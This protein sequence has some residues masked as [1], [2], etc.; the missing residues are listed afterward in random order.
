MYEILMIL[1]VLTYDSKKHVPHKMYHLYE[2]NKIL[3]FYLL[4]CQLFIKLKTYENSDRF[5]IKNCNLVKIRILSWFIC[6]TICLIALRN[7]NSNIILIKSWAYFNI[8]SHFISIKKSI[9]INLF[10]YRRD[11]K[12]SYFCLFSPVL[13]QT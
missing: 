3:N 11:P 8:S 5:I 10:L 13:L 12:R 4:W 1:Y 7:T 6:V 9:S 2:F